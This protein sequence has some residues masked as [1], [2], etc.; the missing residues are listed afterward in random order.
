MLDENAAPAG[1]TFRNGLLYVA[2][3]G[4]DSVEVFDGNSINSIASIRR[5]TPAQS[6]M[7]QPSFVHF[8]SN[9]NLL[10]STFRGGGPAEIFVWDGSSVELLVDETTA[11]NVGLFA[12]AGIVTGPDGRIYVASLGG[13]GV[14]AFASNG[15]P[16]S[17]FNIQIPFVVPPTAS[18]FPTNAPADVI[19]DG[20]D[21]LI[22]VLGPTR[23]G[24][25]AGYPLGGLLRYTA[26]GDLITLAYEI[27][28][29]SSFA[30][31][32]TVPEPAALGLGLVGLGLLGCWCLK[33]RRKP[34][35]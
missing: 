19:M 5:A 22:A 10:I 7:V 14:V 33:R 12:A 17:P 20:N 24:E 26:G 16:T 15:V 11:T 13:N 30:L 25:A 28:S 23:P 2:D 34:A 3:Q 31:F 9:G 6:A 21:L 32:E 18:F 4:G 1:L 8:D 27:D 29:A 35:I